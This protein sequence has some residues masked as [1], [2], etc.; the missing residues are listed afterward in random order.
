[1][2]KELNPKLVIV[3]TYNEAEVIESFIG[4]VLR[5]YPD[6]D[7][8]IVDD[9]SPDGTGGIVDRLSREEPRIHCLHRSQKQGIGPAY[10]DGFKWAIQ[11]GYEY[12]IQ[13]DADFSHDPKYLPS[14]F[15]LA[16]KYDLVIGSRY[17]KG[18]G[19]ENWGVI[20]KI[21]SRCGS[22]YAHIIL[23]LPVNDLT[24]GFKCW[25]KDTLK[26]I[27]L[28]NIATRGY[29]FQIETTFRAYKKGASIKE[30][31]IVFTD[32]RVGETKMSRDIF[33]E[34]MI[35]VLKLRKGA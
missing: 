28:D 2:S 8:L 34:A 27:D 17:V 4:E 24:G 19:I 5:A 20:R 1:M 9:N 18:G 33:I 15:K 30:F 13:M 31:P 32:R 6:T 22:L 14:L 29:G 23:A 10:I 7:V 25:K 16:K 21:I 26:K 3:P 12:I 11:K 35:S